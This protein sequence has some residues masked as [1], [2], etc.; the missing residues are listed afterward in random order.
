MVKTIDLNCDMGESF[1]RYTLGHDD[2]VIQ[3][4]SSVNVACGFH[5]GDPDVMDHTVKMAKK[6]GVGIGAHPSFPDLLGFGRWNMDIPADTLKN[7][8]IYQIGALQAFCQKHGVKMQHVKPHGNL[9]NMA[10]IDRD[11]ATSIVEAVHSIDPALPLF[12]KP[13]SELEHV[14][15]EKGQPALLELFADRA[16]HRDRTLVSR[17]NKGAVITDPEK[18]AQNVLRMILENKVLTIEGEEI[19][20]SGE[21]ICVHGD[22]PTA[23]NMIKVIRQ[24]LAEQGITVRSPLKSY[25]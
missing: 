24:A 19:E 22:T 1:G 25:V 18:A 6:Y 5:G 8:I 12:V 15:K 13:N 9:N 16:Y 20:I 4:V 3:L 21:T 17:R 7:I 2:E 14:A 11:I 23:V 10:D